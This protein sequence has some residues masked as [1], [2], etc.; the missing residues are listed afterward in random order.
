MTSTELTKQIMTQKH[1][2]TIA[3]EQYLSKLREYMPGSNLYMREV[4]FVA[5]ASPQRPVMIAD[6]AQTL[7]VTQGAVS[8]IATRLEKKGYIKRTRAKEDKRQIYVELTASGKELYKHHQRFDEESIEKVCD[9][10]SQHFTDQELE[11]IIEY[12]KLCCQIFTDN[13][14]KIQ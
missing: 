2:A 14:E 12:E 9:V 4:H 6:I 11:K 7:S 13:V 10:F 5:A 3:H 8:Q 1:S